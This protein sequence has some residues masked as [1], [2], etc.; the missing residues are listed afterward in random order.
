M[1][2]H[3]YLSYCRQDVAYVQRLVQHLAAAGLPVWVDQHLAQGARWQPAQEPAIQ[4][5]AVVLVVMS[6]AAEASD[7]VRGESE[8][9]SR[10]LRPRGLAR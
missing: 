10:P 2:G 6:P 8:R 4:A 9:R 5:A 7:R 3:A 1:A